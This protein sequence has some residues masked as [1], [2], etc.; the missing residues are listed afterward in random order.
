MNQIQN[1]TT[2]IN[3]N[4]T[5]I[6]NIKEN[7][8]LNYIDVDKSELVDFIFNIYEDSIINL[9]SFTWD[10]NKDINILINLYK[11]CN[12]YINVNSIT[13]NNKKTNIF[14]KAT[15]KFD[16]SYAYINI[17]ISGIING[18]KSKISCT[19]IFDFNTNKINAHHGLAI[20]TF[21]SD[22]IFALNCK[23]ISTQNAKT[24]LIWSKFYDS[25]NLLLEIEK[26]NLYNFILNK[27]GEN[28]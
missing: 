20:G 7:S 17:Q 3:D 4:I 1:K 22:Q 18:T 23:G 11:N 6:L 21:N 13:I 10:K 24:M 8:L 28:E 12:V 27:W 5:D 2:I 25:I 9:S 14:I 19:P 26:E 16:I 15:N